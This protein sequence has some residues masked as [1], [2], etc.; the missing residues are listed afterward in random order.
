MNATGPAGFA[1]TTSTGVRLPNVADYA[2]AALLLGLLIAAGGTTFLIKAKQQPR[3]R[4]SI[5]H[6]PTGTAV[7]GR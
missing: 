3:T 1:A 7:A 4:S 6:H 2:I 5:P